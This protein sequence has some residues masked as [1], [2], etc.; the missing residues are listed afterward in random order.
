MTTQTVNKE[1]FEYVVNILF[2]VIVD[3]DCIADAFI[4]EKVTDKN[5]K[6]YA[7][8][9]IT[10]LMRRICYDYKFLDITIN[11][12]SNKDVS[13]TFNNLTD[14][15]RT[16]CF[17][18]FI[19]NNSDERYHESLDLFYQSLSQATEILQIVSKELNINLD[20]NSETIH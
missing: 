10:K 1:D 17:V 3:I 14:K 16:S 11:C 5:K 8:M 18:D 4:S 13:T 19:T 7:L 2:N 6:M 12:F 20:P 9:V 15:E